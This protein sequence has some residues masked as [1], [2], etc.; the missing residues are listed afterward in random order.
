MADNVYALICPHCRKEIS[1][2]MAANLVDHFRITHIRDEPDA[3]FQEGLCRSCNGPII[4]VNCMAHNGQLT[5]AIVDGT[6]GIVA[7]GSD[8]VDLLVYPDVVPS[9]A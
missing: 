2:R 6:D 8:Y 3:I 4:L 9:P 5:A 7:L 1:Y